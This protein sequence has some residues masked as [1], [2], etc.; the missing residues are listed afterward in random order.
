M[1]SSRSTL[2]SI[3]YAV[4]ERLTACSGHGCR[5]L[6]FLWQDNV[7]V[8]VN[9][10]LKVGKRPAAYKVIL[11]YL[12]KNIYRAPLAVGPYW[13]VRGAFKAEAPEGKEMS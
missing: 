1:L 10:L 7:K 6:L 3:S 12:L 4:D 11:F 13:L 2:L 8:K 9:L 5:N